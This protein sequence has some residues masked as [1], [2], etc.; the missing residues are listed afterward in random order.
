MWNSKKNIVENNNCVDRI[1]VDEDSSCIQNS[2]KIYRAV[3]FS[4]NEYKAH[5]LCFLIS[6][7]MVYINPKV[8]RKDRCNEN[9]RLIDDDD[10]DNNNKEKK[11]EK[12]Y[13]CL[14]KKKIYLR[15]NNK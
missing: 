3:L 15:Q 6:L 8:S 2:K 13:R 9:I 4:S 7:Y 5:P 11:R 10:V 12:I 1:V 14:T